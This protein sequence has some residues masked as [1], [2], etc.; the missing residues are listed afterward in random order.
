MPAI[1]P[2]DAWQ[3]I[4]PAMALFMLLPAASL[5]KGIPA[6]PYL[7]AGRGTCTVLLIPQMNSSDDGP[8]PAAVR[9]GLTIFAKYTNPYPRFI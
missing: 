3:C 7:D 4:Q 8:L 1:A 6:A 2:A 9:L 5:M